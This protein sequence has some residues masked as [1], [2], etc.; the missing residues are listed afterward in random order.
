MSG[1]RRAG[2]ARA[3]RGGASA[4]SGWSWS[5]GAGPSRAR[6]SR[7]GRATQL[8]GP[9][10]VREAKEG[11]PAPATLGPDAHW[12]R[13]GPATDGVAAFWWLP[14]FGN[15]NWSTP[16]H[17]PGGG[18][19]RP[20]PGGRQPRRGAVG[21]ADGGRPHQRASPSA[22][23][24][25]SGTTTRSASRT[26]PR[27][28]GSTARRPR[29]RVDRSSGSRS[30]GRARD[31]VAGGRRGRDLERGRRA[32][33]P[34]R[35]D[36]GR[37]GDRR[38][39]RSSGCRRRG[40]Q[41]AGGRRQARGPSLPDAP[42]ADARPL[43]GRRLGDR[44]PRRTRASTSTA[45]P[46]RSSRT[47]PTRTQLRLPTDDEIAGGQFVQW[48]RLARVAERRVRR[49]PRR[50]RAHHGRGAQR[51]RGARA[52][53][54]RPCPNPVGSVGA[55][56]CAS[57]PRPARPS[58][59]GDDR[60]RRRCP[61]AAP[62]SAM[63]ASATRER[64]PRPGAPG[65]GGARPADVH[66]PPVAATV[67]AVPSGHDVGRCP[68]RPAVRPLRATGVSTPG[69]AAET[70]AEA[71]ARRVRHGAVPDV[72]PVA[73]SPARLPR[74]ASADA[75]AF[76][77]G[78]PPI[79]DRV[80]TSPTGGTPMPGGG[81]APGRAARRRR[82]R[83]RAGAT[84]PR[85]SAAAASIGARAFTSG[86]TIFLGRG[87]SPHDI[88]L[89]AHEATH[90]AQQR[91]RGP[92]GRRPPRHDPRDRPPVLP[93]SPTSP[94]PTSSRTGSSTASAS[95]VRVDP[96]LHAADP[97]H[98]H[99]PAHRR[100]RRGQPAGELIEELLTYGPFG[101]AVGAVLQAIDVLGEVF[102]VRHARAS[103]RN[104]LTLAR[105]ERDI[106][107]AWAECRSPTASTATSRSSSGYVDALLADVGRV[108]R[109][110]RRAR[111]RDRPRGR[112]RPSP[113]RCSTAP[114][115]RAGLE[116]RQEGPPLRPAARRA[117]RGARRPRSSPTS[118]A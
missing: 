13:C 112:R 70:H 37:A 19:R 96:R 94:S 52:G 64:R 81:A 68:V 101:A 102:D 32:R 78:L 100:A 65:G 74:A 2:G 4:R 9:G 17:R 45:T 50:G 91:A 44:R 77:V 116:P 18:R 54:R 104:G 24:D 99:R 39:G 71:V 80:L 110:D 53:R 49:G 25:R 72:S 60:V 90:V 42:A 6:R 105:I 103:A 29:R 95:A 28:S 118:C 35:R 47:A 34:R 109:R 5:T 114:R 113:S 16:R 10:R 106:D 83:R 87:Q 97:H 3:G 1:R 89:M 58:S 117:R 79:V 62:G 51:D 46:R 63:A 36:R 31:A 111:P 93:A 30:A 86:S 12:S 7:P 61:R 8:T 38:R 40:R 84:G 14:F 48:F 20:D 88:A 82:P 56:S 92:R 115:D 59:K 26:S 67:A 43:R 27:G 22:P 107:A 69:D 108:R 11:E 33:G 21:R 41:V 55:G 85:A 76:S 98:R 73:G 75:G 15:G 23:S 66:A 57:T